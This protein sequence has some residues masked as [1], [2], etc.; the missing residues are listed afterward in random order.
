MTF[1]FKE[2]T[3]GYKNIIMFRKTHHLT[4]TDGNY[5]LLLQNV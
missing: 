5:V 1:I 2:Y 3:E 4:L